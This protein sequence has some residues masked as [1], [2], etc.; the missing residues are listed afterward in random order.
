MEEFGNREPVTC[1]QNYIV[2]DKSTDIYHTR[3]HYPVKPYSR[4]SSAYDDPTGLHRIVL[5]G[6]QCRTGA[7]AETINQDSPDKEF[8]NRTS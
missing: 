1:S 7:T 3:G 4:I 8:V 5:E 6:Y 2:S